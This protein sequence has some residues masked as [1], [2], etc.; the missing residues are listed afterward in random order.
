ME[1]EKNEITDGS[2][3]GSLWYFNPWAIAASMLVFGPLGLILVWLRPETKIH[4]KILISVA[5]I[6]LTVWMTVGAVNYYQTLAA[7][8]RQLAVDMKGM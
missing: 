8:Y 3:D 4:I 7:Y 1:K 6:G 2:P 5:V